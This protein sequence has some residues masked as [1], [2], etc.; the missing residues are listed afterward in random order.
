MSK[1]I[2]EVFYRDLWGLAK[3]KRRSLL[4]GDAGPYEA[5][6][7]TKARRWKLVPY[8]AA[9]GYED[10]PALDELFP[11]QSMGINTNRGQD[12]SLI[13]MEKQVLAQRMQGYYSEEEWGTFASKHPVLATPRSRYQPEK[14]RAQLRKITS[15]QAERILPYLNLPLDL[16]WIYYEDVGKLISERSPKLWENLPSNEFLVTVSEPRQKSESR[17]LLTHELFGLHLHDRGSTGFLATHRV[18]VGSGLF[19]EGVSEF[20]NLAEPAW[21]ALRGPEEVT[22]ELSSAAA[23]NLVRTLFRIVLALGHSPLFES[24]HGQSL[25]QDWLHLPIPKDRQLFGQLASAGDKVAILL[26]PSADAREVL[27]ELLGPWYPRLGVV[28][29]AADAIGPPDYAVSYSYFGGGKGRWESRLAKAEDWPAAWGDQTGELYLNPTTYLANVPEKVWRYQLGGYPVIKK[30][31]GYRDAKRRSGNP[32]TQDELAHLRSIVQRL[33]A[34]H[35]LH[36]QLDSLY[37]RIGSDVF[38]AEELGLR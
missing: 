29:R 21:R 16:R 13:E 25:G 32:L 23:K 37:E 8:E 11:E 36:S 17:P 38:T 4:D 12:G 3:D 33:A 27:Q 7:P 31:L 18:I 10:W 19:E 22:D 34:L 15:F 30:W 24:D 35:I 6:A 14:L 28:S 26:D 2:A 20:A 5:F 1:K 9:G